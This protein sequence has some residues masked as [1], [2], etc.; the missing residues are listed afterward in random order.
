MYNTDPSSDYFMQVVEDT[1][2]QPGTTVTITGQYTPAKEASDVCPSCGYCKS[3]GR[4]GHQTMPYYP[5]Y[6]MPYYPGCPTYPTWYNSS[7]AGI[8]LQFPNSPS[9]EFE[10]IEVDGTQFTTTASF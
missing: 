10:R 8:A 5:Y 7:G 6:P 4:G 9:G 1:T 2:A 3:C